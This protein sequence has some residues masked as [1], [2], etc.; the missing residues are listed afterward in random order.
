V[1]VPSAADWPDPRTAEQRAADLADDYLDRLQAGQL[2]DRKALL[3]AHP[4][5]A[6]LLEQQLRLVEVMHEAA[7]TVGPAANVSEL[8]ASWK[9]GRRLGRYTLRAV[10]GQGASAT[11]YRAYDPKYDREV[12]LKVLRPERWLPADAAD[13]FARDARIA[14]Q[15]RH[16]HIVPLHEAG[17]HGG[18]R[19]LDMEL[20]RGET[21]EARLKR[22]RPSFREA[23]ELVRKV[24]L[25][26]DY[27]HSQGIIHR[28]VKPSNILLE[29]SGQAAV[30]S[31]EKQTQVPGP[32]LRV[33]APTADS[34]LPAADCLLPQLTDF[35]LARRDAGEATLTCEGQVL[36]TPRYMSPEQAR[37][38]ARQ[39]DGRSDTYSLGVVLYQL[40]TGRVPFADADGL[41]AHLYHIVHTDPPAPRTLE[42]AVP[43]DLET[44]CLKALAKDPADRFATAAEF[45]EELGR[46]LRDESLRIRPPTAW[47]RLRRWARRNRLVTAVAGAAAVLLALTVTVLGTLAWSAHERDRL[48]ARLLAEVEQQKT[49]YEVRTLLEK[50]RQRLRRPTGGRR[51]ETQQLLWQIAEPLRRLGPGPVQDELNLEAR[52]LYVASFAVPDLR[53]ADRAKF[54]PG[55]IRAWSAALH[56]DGN[57][58]AIGTKEW[59]VHWECGKPLTIPPAAA[60]SLLPPTM[61]PD[62][63]GRPP[64]RREDKKVSHGRPDCTA[65]NGG[66]NRISGELLPRM[67]TPAWRA[68]NNF[69]QS[70]SGFS[71][72]S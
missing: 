5:I 32:P 2:P 40:L 46:W 13:R 59:P 55:G 66:R 44:I 4:D 27:A 17:Q 54:P 30:G 43:R 51:L 28:D 67:G 48:R 37:G 25:A 53:V 71:R 42:P 22:G 38:D 45:A 64:E 47:E 36:G 60:A 9:P 24:A 33:V 72:G 70:L 65:G 31:R 57:R 18:I 7:H 61:P 58:M 56:P 14:A 26:L 29:G 50:A 11:V 39:V 6:A 69:Q 49:E 68:D 35:G 8:A 21:L 12:A 63:M 34:L 15:L 19:Y 20:V 1:N 41:S 62:D 52:S 10:L 3:A 23:A 16:P